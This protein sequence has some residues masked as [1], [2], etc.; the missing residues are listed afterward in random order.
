M[1]QPESKGPSWSSFTASQSE[2]HLLHPARAAH[3]AKLLSPGLCCHQG[4]AVSHHQWCPVS[5]GVAAQQWLLPVPSS[6][7]H[8]GSGF[9]QQWQL[10]EPRNGSCRS[11]PGQERP[12]CF[13]WEGSV[14]PMLLVQLG[15]MCFPA[16][17]PQ[18]KALLKIYAQLVLLC[19]LE[20]FSAQLCCFML[21]KWPICVQ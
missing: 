6:V 13:P 15:W 8:P 7:T 11:L 3:A 9:R 1:E 16:A 14:L 18:P 19:R 17:L 10:L 12:L 4:C 21:L 2:L 5:S 20:L